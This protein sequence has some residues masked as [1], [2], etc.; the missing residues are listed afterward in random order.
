[1]TDDVVPADDLDGAAAFV[2]EQV[3]ADLARDIA[4]EARLIRDVLERE[5]SELRG[6]PR[7]LALLGAS[8]EGNV[9][10][11]L[12]VV[13]EGV[14]AARLQA[15]EAAIDYARHLA[16]TTAPVTAL[17]RAYRLGYTTF[18]DRVYGRMALHDIDPAIRLPVFHRIGQIGSTYIDWVSET[19]VREY[20]DERE[21]WLSHRDAQRA[22]RIRQILTGPENIDPASASATLDYRLDRTH[23]ALIAWTADA[24]VGEAHHLGREVRSYAERSGASAAPLIVPADDHTVW[25]WFPVP[26][27]VDIPVDDT[28][29]PTYGRPMTPGIHMAVGAP[30]SGLAGFRRSHREATDAQRIA[31]LAAAGDTG[32]VVDYTTPG[33]AVVAQLSHDFDA[34]DDWIAG[35]LGDLAHPTEQAGRL[36]TTLR[37]FLQ[38]NGSHKATAAT[39]HLHPN[40]IKYRV[41]AAERVLGAPLSTHR[42]D[43]EIALLVAQWRMPG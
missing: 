14:P 37:E 33:V 20:Q 39:L 19:V 16:R 25:A 32:S 15:P 10:T 8:V 3:H 34:V 17:V 29:T 27:G 18:M 24:A 7:L 36:R 41:A 43:V 1:M 9:A 21:R 40:T 35:I 22:H 38:R 42:L 11:F 30:H 4:G 31:G 26:A 6:D 5:I 13:R 2:V 28:P 23:R 12:R